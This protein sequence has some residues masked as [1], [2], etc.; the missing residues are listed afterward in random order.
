VS[1]ATSS[2]LF[3]ALAVVCEG[4]QAGPV[5][6]ALGVVPDAAGHTD[7]FSF[8]LPPYASISLGADGMLGGEPAGRVAGFWRALHLDPPAEP[9]HLAALLGLYAALMEAEADETDPARRRLRGEARRALLAEHLAPWVP[10]YATAAIRVASAGYRPWA[11]ALSAAVVAE[12]AAAGLAAPARDGSTGSLPLHLREAPPA[13]E[14]AD[15][16]LEAYLG[17]LLAPVASGI[18]V[19]R[20]DLVEAARRFGLGL[21][22]GERRFVLSALVTQDPAAVA[23]WL[24]EEAGAWAEEHDRLVPVLGDT[25]RFWRARARGTE[26]HLRRLLSSDFRAA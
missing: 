18:V 11:E 24:A 4:P 1:A 13:A 12:A 3:R 15:D 6:A 16:G 14:P 26:A 25:A 19:T 21:R 20:R 17:R 2:E 23:G 8:Q 22:M 7:L 9:D 5:A 10:A